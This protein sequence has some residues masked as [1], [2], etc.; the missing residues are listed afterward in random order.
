MRTATSIP[1]PQSIRSQGIVELDAEAPSVNG[2]AALPPRA[3]LTLAAGTFSTAG[4][5]DLSAPRVVPGCAGDHPGIHQLL[6]AVFHAPTRDAFYS[7]LDDPYYEPRDRLLVKRGDRI[8]AH[9]HLTKRV[10][11]FGPMM[12]PVSGLSW[13]CTLPEFRG[14]GFARQLLRTADRTMAADGA[15]LGLLSTKLPHFFRPAGWAVCGRQSQ[16]HAGTRELLAQLSA[17]ALPPAE[18]AFNIRPLRQMELSSVMRLYA[19]ATERSIGPFERSEAYW[20]WLVS[21]KG[22]DQVLI[23]ID[24]PDRLELDGSGSPI[25]GYAVTRGESI[26]ELVVDPDHPSAAEQLLA[27]ACG[28]AIER[29][30]HA[31]QLHAPPGERLFG[32]FQAASGTLHQ[33][34]AHQGEVF[35]VKLLDPAGFL[36]LLLGELNV[37][38]EATALERPCE[39]GLHVEDRK[40]RLAVS[41]RSVKLTLNKLGR[42][43]LRM[44][45]AEFTRLLLG[46]LDLHEAVASGRVTSST[47]L[48]LEIG[49]VLFPRLPLWR[50]P[51]DDLTG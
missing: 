2:R 15:M 20:R 23:A 6:S 24:G 13:I 28:E 46:H 16:A 30:D 43:Y 51:F 12:L 10:M 7:S 19:R 25:V 42:S 18:G 45:L 26:V 21:R 31:V 38:S 32:L 14:L 34:E 29:D 27:R 33:T 9:L 11:H 40:Y 39:L 35:M 37:R 41:R 50:P 17:M 1:V 4:F 48:A 44:N 3:G 8:I 49:Q 22:F 36:R 47:R 5:R